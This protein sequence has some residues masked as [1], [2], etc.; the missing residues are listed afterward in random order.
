M[1]INAVYEADLSFSVGVGHLQDNFEEL[2]AV[3]VK[4]PQP[5]VDVHNCLR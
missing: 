2:F 1:V 4:L 5:C 3:W